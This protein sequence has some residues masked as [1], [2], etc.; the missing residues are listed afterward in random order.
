MSTW[1]REK[2]NIRPTLVSNFFKTNKKRFVADFQK[3]CLQMKFFDTK[4]FK[5]ILNKRQI[6]YINL[7]K[8]FIF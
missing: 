4:V 5:I 3:F 1:C 6:Y 7:L 2:R 8:I